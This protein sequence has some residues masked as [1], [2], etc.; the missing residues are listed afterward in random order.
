MAKQMQQA[1]SKEG[2]AARNAWW[3]AQAGRRDRKYA[4][5]GE[6]VAIKIYK[7]QDNGERFGLPWSQSA[8]IHWSTMEEAQEAKAL[9]EKTNKGAR[10]EIVA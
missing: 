9:L 3:A 7:L 5:A 4:D 10:F 2:T 8:E 6:S 1:G